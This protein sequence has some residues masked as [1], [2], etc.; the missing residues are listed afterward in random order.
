LL[1]FTSGGG[2]ASAPESF[3]VLCYVPGLHS[4]KE[5]QVDF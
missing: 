2:G 4:D 1:W 3:P 5:E